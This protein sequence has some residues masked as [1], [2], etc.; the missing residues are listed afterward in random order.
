M[1][2]LGSSDDIALTLRSWTLDSELIRPR[3]NVCHGHAIEAALDVGG[4]IPEHGVRH[5]ARG[6]PLVRSA[7]IREHDGTFERADD[8]SD[9]DVRRSACQVVAA[10]RPPLGSHD[11]CSL[12]ILEDL[13]EKPG[14]DAL[15]LRDPH[16]GS[17]GCPSG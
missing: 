4:K 15:P 12:Q 11:P 7:V 17:G 3:A 10:L 6:C 13:L 1:E 16:R 5:A 2:L 14:R 8:V 9:T